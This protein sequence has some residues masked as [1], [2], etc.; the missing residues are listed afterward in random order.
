[1]A[2]RV[3]RQV[4]VRRARFTDPSEPALMRLFVRGHAGI[5]GAPRQSTRSNSG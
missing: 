1:M 4:G 2:A 3:L 5:G